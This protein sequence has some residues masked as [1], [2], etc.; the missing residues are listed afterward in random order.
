MSRLYVRH[1]ENSSENGNYGPRS[2]RAC[3]QA[4]NIKQGNTQTPRKVH[5]PTGTRSRGLKTVQQSGKGLLR[6]WYFLR[7]MRRGCSGKN[8]T[9]DVPGTGKNTLE[10]PAR[11]ERGPVE[12]LTEPLL[13]AHG[14][15]KCWRQEKDPE[16]GRE[17]IMEVQVCTLSYR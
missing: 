4:G 9:E 11:Q 1:R 16:A 14:I 10:A 3:G 2:H 15:H 8:G 17:W 5:V 6:E 12:A 7:K 13:L